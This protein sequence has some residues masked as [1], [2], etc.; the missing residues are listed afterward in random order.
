MELIQISTENRNDQKNGIDRKYQIFS[1]KK[2]PKYSNND[3]NIE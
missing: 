1:A 3:N 2:K